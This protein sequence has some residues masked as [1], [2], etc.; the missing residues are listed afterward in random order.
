MA[1]TATT[2]AKSGIWD[3]LAW[4]DAYDKNKEQGTNLWQSA[5]ASSANPALPGDPA[6]PAPP[7]DPAPG[8]SYGGSYGSSSGGSSGGA[9]DTGQQYIEAYRLKF[10]KG[11]KPPSDILQKAIANN[12][13]IAYFEQQVRL[14]DK[15]YYKS[16]EARTL[17][18][19]FNTTMKVLFPGLSDKTR[20]AALMKSPLYK[21]TALW[22]LKNGVGLLG[23]AGMEILYNRITGTKQWN[24]NNPAYRAYAKNKD[25]TVQAE[26]NPLVFKQLEGAMKTAFQQLGMQVDDSYYKQFFRSRYASST[27]VRDLADNLSTIASTAGSYSW[28]QGQ[29]ND[30]KTVKTAAFNAG[31]QGTDLRSRMNQA[32]GVRQS[33]LKSDARGFGTDVS[34]QGKLVKTTL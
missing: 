26:L 4:L 5:A 34:E 7:S 16:L 12:W 24:R 21:R 15:S 25:A 27:G 14:K 23:D 31:K 30:D 33:F 10:F 11:E 28:F 20:Q 22:Y 19:Q 32:F 2:A 1:S 3:P 13:S 18:P 8:G 29:A 6:D 17:L 9:A